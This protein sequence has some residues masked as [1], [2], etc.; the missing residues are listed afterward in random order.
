MLSVEPKR[1]RRLVKDR[2][3]GCLLQVWLDDLCPFARSNDGV[4]PDRSL[5]LTCLLELSMGMAM[6]HEGVVPQ[7]TRLQA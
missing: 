1:A 6:Q 3:A 2:A 7:E 5:R 4:R